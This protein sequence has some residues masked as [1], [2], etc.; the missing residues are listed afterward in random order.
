MAYFTGTLL[1]SPVVRGSAADTYGTHH[2]VLGVGGYMELKT[3]AE[4]NALPISDPGALT[5][6]G[7]ASGQRRLGMLVYVHETD[8]I[9]KLDIPYTTWN[10]YNLTQKLDALENNSNWTPLDLGGDISGDRIES[11]LTQTGHGFVIGDVIGHNGSFYLKVDSDIA[12]SVEPLGIVSEVNGDEFVV[13]YSGY[14]DTTSIVDEGSLMLSDGTLYYL[15]EIE[16]KITSNEPI[17]DGLVSKPVLVTID[18]NRGIVLQY[19][20]LVVG[21]QVIGATNLGFFSGYT[22]VQTLKIFAPGNNEDG[23]YDSLYNYY[24]RDFDGVIRLGAPEYDGVKRRGY[25]KSS[26]PIRSWI[27]N[28]ETGGWSF[29]DGDVSQNV[30]NF[31]NYVAYDNP[32]F[33]ETEWFESPPLYFNSPTNTVGIEVDGNL[34]SGDFIANGGPVFA[35]KKDGI[36]EFRTIIS[37]NEDQIKVIYDEN[38]IKISGYTTGQNITSASGIGLFKETDKNIHKF[39]SLK[40]S[41]DTVIEEIGDDVI[42]YTKSFTGETGNVTGGLNLGSGEGQV[43]I[44]V[45]GGEMLFRT[46]KAGTNIDISHDGNNIVFDVPSVTDLYD[47]SSPS[48]VT[49]GGLDAGSV[50]TGKTANQILQDILVPTLY[51]TCVAPNNTFVK[52]SPAGTLFEIGFTTNI[53]FTSTHIRGQILL[54]GSFQNTRSGAPISHDYT[55][56]GL[57]GIVYTNNDVN[58]QTSSNYLILIGNQSWTARVNYSAG[59][60][61]LDSNGDPYNGPPCNGPLAQGYTFYKSLQIEGVYPLFATSVNLTTLTKQSL[62]SMLTGNNVVINLVTESGGNKQK[63]DIPDAWLGAPTN[64]P[65]I[66]IETYNTFSNQWE[67]QGGTAVNSLTFWNTTSVQQTI[68]GNSINYTRYEFNGTNRSAVQIRLK[69]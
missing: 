52:S 40:A 7:I 16:G 14:I 27:F 22:S 26:S 45:T 33:T 15:S 54:D 48:T 20:G 43:F 28:D 67:Y 18:G 3:V 53:N 41:G 34:T 35:N 17:E 23:D 25:L 50:L 51:P 56:V 44:N 69:F 2:S 4:R 49:V 42:I 36:L 47:L 24:Y 58:S 64:R 55:G 8:T 61:P 12:N 63:F 9:Y 21:E 6:D 65:L 59:P 5:Y 60:Q 10:G 13:V 68:Q 62:V 11:T 57:P 39:K 19:R 66:G 29:I 30:G 32:Q 1:A 38:F 31:M 37:D 46:L